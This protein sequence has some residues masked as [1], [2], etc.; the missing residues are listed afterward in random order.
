MNKQF[1]FVVT[2]VL[3]LE[4][5][6]MFSVEPFVFA[7]EGNA[8]Q[9]KKAFAMASIVSKDTLEGKWLYLIYSEAFRRLDLQLVFQHYPSL[10][11]SKMA[12]EHKVEGELARVSQYGKK[13]PNL[14]RVEEPALSNSFIAFATNPKI[15]LKGWES[16]RE[17]K[18][19]VEYFRGD[20][21]AHDKL[22]E[23]VI[24]AQ[25]SNISS[26]PQGFKKLM[27]GRTDVFVA[28]ETI[29]NNLLKQDEFQNSGIL[30]VGVMEKITVHAYLHKNHAPFAPQLSAILKE[31][32]KEGLIE[33]YKTISGTD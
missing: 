11:A 32:K 23:I 21:R 29:A 7:K 6:I 19:K 17:T 31:M 33:K 25:L 3:V 12:D 16:L 27:H 14:V 10:R 22:T 5:L 1:I 13:H 26:W 24:P 15:K 4:L 30:L 8:E 28:P 2:F 9:K 20:Q 18:Y